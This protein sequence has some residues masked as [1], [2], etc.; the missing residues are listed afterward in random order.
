[1]KINIKSKIVE[2]F[3]LGTFSFCSLAGL[4]CVIMLASRDESAMSFA[5]A[6]LVCF[7]LGI[8][9]ERGFGSFLLNG[10]MG[11]F[12]G[13]LVILLPVIGSRGG[14]SLFCLYLGTAAIAIF[15]AVA[16]TFAYKILI[17]VSNKAKHINAN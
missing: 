12:I 11:Q 2:K 5:L 10:I 1:M 7:P 13:V 8:T 14:I 17:A 4:M 6:G 9:A 15:I 3:D 16:A